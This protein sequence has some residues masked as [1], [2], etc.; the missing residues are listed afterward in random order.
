ML[1]SVIFGNMKKAGLI[2]RFYR[3]WL[4]LSLLVDACCVKLLCNYGLSI[5]K[6]IFWLKVIVNAVIAV[7][8]HHYKAREFY[9]Y[10]NLGIAKQKLLIISFTAD[11][12]IYSLL[13]YLTWKLK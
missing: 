5:V 12:L 1:L 2:F 9:Y 11:F 8:L 4:T 6:G 3:S 7:W 10:S 13:L